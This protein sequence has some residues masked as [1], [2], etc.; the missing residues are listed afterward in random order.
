M[1]I[2]FINTLY[3]PHIGGGAEVTLQNLAESMKRQG[4]EVCIL[5]T[6]PHRGLQ[7]EEIRGIHVYR[8]GLRNIFFHHGAPVLPPVW[9]RALWHLIDIYN[10][11]M[12]RYV[13]EVLEREQPDVVSCHGLSGWSIAPWD[14]IYA[15]G[16]PIVQVLHD[17]YLLSP[18]VTMSKKGQPN[19]KPCLLCSLMRMIHRQRSNRAVAVVGV[20]QFILNKFLAQGYFRKT[21]V[22]TFI[23]NTRN[24]NVPVDHD[25][26]RGDKI[27]F[28]F[29]GTLAA[30]KGIELLL[31]TFL[32]HGM[33][34]WRLKV[35]GQGKADYEAMLKQRFHHPGIE[36]L[37]YVQPFEF[38]PNLDITVV[39][40]LWEEPLGMVVAESLMY[41]VPV[42]GS[43]RGGIPEMLQDERLGRL[44]DPNDPSGLPKAMAAMA[45]ECGRYR[46]LREEICQ[47]SIPFRD[48]DAWGK[49][50]DAVYRQA[51]EM[52]KKC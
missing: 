10:P 13:R 19:S 25:S 50:W 24:F 33:A 45:D 32:K 52:A 40:S 48:Q 4:H 5:A 38:F 42:L 27:T 16:V 1:K 51:N 30:H 17:Y 15:R 14:V 47:C 12:K 39:P 6:G 37:S 36:F 28:G 35:A 49:K 9:K 7:E 3:S 46:G 26:S 43:N 34:N 8:A 11:F 31:E 44:F 18:K 20:S 23:H 21:P 41:G 22:K 29:I 2:L